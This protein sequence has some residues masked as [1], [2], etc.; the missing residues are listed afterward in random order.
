MGSIWR[1]ARKSGLATG[2]ICP[3]C[4]RALFHARVTGA[5]A[6]TD[7]DLCE[8][9]MHF[10]FDRE[11]LERLPRAT[12]AEIKER[13]EPVTRNINPPPPQAPLN[14]TDPENDCTDG[15]YC[16]NRWH[17]HGLNGPGDLGLFVAVVIQSAIE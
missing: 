1:E 3:V 5:T 10:W 9:C 12:P 16:T 6:T 7:L 15:L 13:S 17:R 2:R 8:E 14:F 4:S 11:E